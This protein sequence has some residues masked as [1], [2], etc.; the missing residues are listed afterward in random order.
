MGITMV[1]IIEKLLQPP[2][3]AVSIV[4]FC[5]AIELMSILIYRKLFDYKKLV[6][7]QKEITKWQ[8]EYISALRSGDKKTLDRLEKKRQKIESMQGEVMKANFIVGLIMMGVIGVSLTIFRKLITVEEKMAFIP[9]INRWVS[10]GSWYFIAFFAV[11][12][13]F[14]RFVG[15]RQREE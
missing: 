5:L 11:S 12:F 3:S 2:G 15:I 8:R 13:I 9:L 6:R 4:L 10:F 14:Q 1:G 7:Y